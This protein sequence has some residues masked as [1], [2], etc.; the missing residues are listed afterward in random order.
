[1]TGT[2]S[3]ALCGAAALMLG[4]LVSASS[5]DAVHL[6]VGFRQEIASPGS[7]FE[8]SFGDA[9]AVDGDTLAV[10]EPTA[11]APIDPP[12]KVHVYRRDPATGSWGDRQEIVGPESG[13]RFGTA[14]AL[15]GGTL[16][17]GAPGGGSSG[18]GEAHVWVRNPA[19]GLW[20]HHQ[21]L[22]SDAVL[23]DRFGTDVAVSGEVVVVGASGDDHGGGEDEVDA[24]V[25]H[26]Y[27]R[28]PDGLWSHVDELR[29]SYPKPN[30]RFG[31][32]VAVDGSTVLVGVPSLVG[33]AGPGRAFAF[34]IGSVHPFSV[35]VPQELTDPGG[36]DGDGFGW[37]VDV[38]G[39]RLV[40]GAYFD[41]GAGSLR[42]AAHVF[43]FDGTWEYVQSVADPGARDFARFGYSV[44]LGGGLLAVG[45]PWDDE[46]GSERGT[47]HLFAEDP[48]TGKWSYEQQ[49]TAPD[50]GNYDWFGRSV[51][52][53]GDWIAVG[54]PVDPGYG[55]RGFAEL[56]AEDSP[57]GIGI[58]SPASGKVYALGSTV[59]AS[60]LCSDAESGIAACLG[61]VANGQ[62]IDTVT[63]GEHTFTVT[64]VNG[65]GNSAV[66]RRTYFVDGSRPVITITSP[67]VGAVHALGS[68]VLASYSCSDPESGIALCE[69]DV[70][71]GEPIDTTTLGMRPFF[72]LAANGAGMHNNSGRFYT[73]VPACDGL[74]VTHE[75]PP[76][77]ARFSG[78]SGDDVI[79][80]TD[81][82]DEIV[83][84]GGNDTICGGGGDDLLLGGPGDDTLLGGDGNDKLRGAAGDDELY[85][86]AGSDR[87]LPETGHD[88]VD[89]GP[90]SDIVDYLAADG[91]VTVDLE[92]GWAVYGP[93]A[94]LAPGQ[95]RAELVRVEKVDGTRFDDTLVGDERR[96]VLRGKQGDDTI[97]G[98]G[99]DDDL[100]GGMGV[101]DVQGGDGD[102]LVKGQADDDV[103]SGAAGSDR[104]VGGGGNDAL[105]GGDGDDTLI[106]GLKVH[107]G[108]FFNLLDGGAGTDVCRWEPITTG[109]P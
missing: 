76:G 96:N 71:I 33:S 77:G 87:L 107:L 72:V 7:V 86:G 22:S 27:A 105:S 53:G 89:G 50:P 103:L 93:P 44:A 70:G 30:D 98:N 12:G 73:V 34:T 58:T 74:P 81:G 18:Q 1:M 32:S 29:S 100:I 23:D 28:Y 60:Y 66:H 14:V 55:G 61:D 13:D 47:V 56:F 91:P 40:V 75:V 90:G 3:T 38:D 94:R 42:G 64:A 79:L 17:I 59:P 20:E 25:A 2:R 35:G 46:G 48:G 65:V 63:A 99:G 68:T 16:V 15:D 97:V 108:V 4:L 43:A 5:A 41:S 19:S 39:G 31:H 9:V 106:G 62:P 104:L 51:A 57:P 85:G 67:E 92:E 49:L 88:L 11:V 21:T 109:C 54:M 84:Y 52:L 45:A 95:W 101:D 37:S 78:T 82:P 36:E 102:D 10:G 69:G 26:V 24:G 6:P 80:G 8:D 83:G